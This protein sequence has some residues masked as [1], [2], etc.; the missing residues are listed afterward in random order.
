MV[1]SD[2]HLQLYDSTGV[3]EWSR[4]NL[5]N[6]RNTGGEQAPTNHKIGFNYTTYVHQ[7]EYTVHDHVTN[8]GLNVIF[9][10][11]LSNI[12]NYFRIQDNSDVPAMTLMPVVMWQS[13]DNHPSQIETW[14]LMNGHLC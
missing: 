7:P 3:W 2:T 11:A 8:V 14:Q 13:A 1:W 9:F 12:W 5:H 4:Y 6:V 10:P